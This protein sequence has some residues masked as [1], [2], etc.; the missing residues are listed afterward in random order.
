MVSWNA[1][2]RAAGQIALIVQLVDTRLCTGNKTHIVKPRRCDLMFSVSRAISEICKRNKLLFR[3]SLSKNAS[4]QATGTG[5]L[6][7]NGVKTASIARK[8]EV[9]HFQTASFLRFIAAYL[10]L[11]HAVTRARPRW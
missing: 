3:F 1:G 7:L 6:V 5:V 11:T 4:S 10:S 2:G 8:S 9:F